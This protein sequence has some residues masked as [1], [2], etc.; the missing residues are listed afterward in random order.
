MPEPHSYIPEMATK[1]GDSG[2]DVE[3]AYEYLRRFGYLPNPDLNRSFPAWHSAIPFAPEDI[4]HFDERLESALTLFQRAYGLEET[5]EVDDA[6]IELMK[7]PRCGFPDVVTTDGLANFVAQGNRWTGPQITYSHTN[8]SPDLTAEQVRTTIREAFDKWTVHIP[9]DVVEAPT[10]DIRIGFFSGNHSDGNNFDGQSGILAHCF[11]PPPYGGDIAGDCHFDEAETWTVNTPPT[12]IDLPSVALH[13]L[14]HGLGLNHSAETS[15]VMY[16]YYGGARRD[17]TADDIDGIRSIYG[18]R[19]RWES[20]GGQISM[21]IVSSNL[22]GR[23]EVFAQGTDGALWHIWQKAPN[24]G[25]SS[26]Q[27]LGGWITQPT[28]GQNADGRLEVFARGAD[29][30]LWHIW[31]KAPNGDWSGWQSLGGVVS[32]PAVGRNKDGRLEVFAQGTDGALHHIWQVKANGTWSNWSSLGGW[33]TNPVV[34][35]NADGR[36][37]VFVQGGD[38]ALHHIWQTAPNNGWSGWQSLGGWIRNPS[39]ARNKDGRL[40]VFIQ[41]GDN[42][43]HHIWQTSPNNN[44]SG[45]ASLGGWVRNPSAI[46]NKDGRIEV[47]VLGGDNAMHHIWQVSP[48]GS[49]GSWSGLAGQ[50]IGGPVVGMNKDGR[51]ETFVKGTDAGLWHAWQS[52]VNG[53]WN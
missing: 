38:N 4:T 52:A 1:L 32:M 10:G 47:F 34:A 16:A 2:T 21:P 43:M 19:F 40:E 3:R 24:S 33:I 29:G 44:W 39:V 41:G 28:V 53:R 50:L 20:L 30:A 37:E 27:S 49:F 7:R 26:W 8:F 14:G 25:W 45:W 36:L 31:Q 46:T 51:L 17:L 15:S 12:G 23:I 35:N 13:E 22:D 48:N 5:G 18:M 9:L 42:A 11:Y 6:T